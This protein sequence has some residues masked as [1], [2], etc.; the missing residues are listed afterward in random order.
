M[1]SNTLLRRFGQVV[2]QQQQALG[3]QALG[4]LGVLDGLTGGATHASQNRHAA[5]AGVDGGLDH[6]RILVSSQGEEFTGTASGKQRG[7][8][9]RGQPLEAAYVALRIE[10]A[11][12]IEIGQREGQQTGGEDGF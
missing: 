10:F 11:L 3:A 2:R 4:F 1:G 6:R 5:G 12:G 8:A 9:V 7:G